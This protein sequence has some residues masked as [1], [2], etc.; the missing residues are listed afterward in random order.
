MLSPSFDRHARCLTG[1]AVPSEMCTVRDSI[2]DGRSRRYQDAQ[3]LSTDRQ[4]GFVRVPAPSEERRT[5]STTRQR[6]DRA[7]RLRDL[8]DSSSS[9]E[10]EREGTETRTSSNS[11]ANFQAQSG[12]LQKRAARRSR[13]DVW[14]QI[15]MAS[16]EP[17][18]RLHTALRTPTEQPAELDRA[19]RSAECHRCAL[20]TASFGRVRMAQSDSARGVF[21][22][23]QVRHVE[24]ELRQ[25]SAE[26]S[27]VRKEL[28][29]MS[30]RE[31]DR[32][33]EMRRMEEQMKFA[34]NASRLVESEHVRLADVEEDRRRLA[35]ATLYP[36]V[37]THACTHV[38]TYV[39]ADILPSALLE[40]SMHVAVHISVHVSVHMSIY[41][42]V[43]VSIHVCMRM[44]IHMSIH[45][46]VH[47]YKHVYI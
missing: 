33:R 40:R 23:C 19:V 28:R 9:S 43:H 46:S 1:R 25:T 30:A 14:H 31:A 5:P 38:Y 44:S 11:T 12:G 16:A 2:F 15:A 39:D 21:F 32:C 36:H 18:G 42:S 22:W 6:R 47:M 10:S 7:T 26:L 37:Y 34:K 3:E 8:T 35:G 41:T 45:M 29:E 20:R 27:G 17:E 24:E 4:R 13:Y